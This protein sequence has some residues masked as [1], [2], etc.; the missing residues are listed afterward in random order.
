M[1]AMLGRTEGATRIRWAHAR[2]WRGRTLVAVRL[3]DLLAPRSISALATAPTEGKKVG[4]IRMPTAALIQCA[5]GKIERLHLVR[6]DP[7]AS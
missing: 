5:T 4:S 6:T 3:N 2:P 7:S 1:L